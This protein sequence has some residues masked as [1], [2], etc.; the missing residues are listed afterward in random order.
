MLDRWFEAVEFDGMRVVSP[1][2]LLAM[3]GA[4]LPEHELVAVAEALV[5]GAENYPGLRFAARPRVALDALR[6]EAVRFVGM[7]GADALTTALDRVRPGV[8]SPMETYLRLRLVDA[9]LPEPEVNVEIRLPSG[10]NVRSDLAYRA[11]RVL[12]D[13]EGDHHR[14]D[15]DTW[16]DDIERV[17]EIVSCGYDHVRVT[18][19]DFRAGRFTAVVEHIRRR[20]G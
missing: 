16:F 6:A 13:Y 20:L 18:R 10:R 1:P 5:T 15:A 17:R 2:L 3:L 19:R 12:I 8:E 11:D 9:G 7:S 4:E 14:T